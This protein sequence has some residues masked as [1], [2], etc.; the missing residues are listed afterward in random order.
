MVQDKNICEVYFEC[1][2]DVSMIWNIN[3]EIRFLYSFSYNFHNSLQM[4]GGWV[5]GG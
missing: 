2:Y 3:Y 5:V 1:T 4:V